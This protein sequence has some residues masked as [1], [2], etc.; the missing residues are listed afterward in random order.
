MHPLGQHQSRGRDRIL[1]L[2]A[3]GAV[4]LGDAFRSAA[5]QFGWP[6]MQ[7]AAAGQA[8]RQIA[9]TRPQGVI[10]LVGTKKSL[11]T[12]ASLISDLRRYQPQLPL[13]AVAEL[14]DEEAERRLRTAGATGYLAG[15]ATCAEEAAD[16]IAAA[17][18]QREP[19]ELV[20]R[21]RAARSPPG[22]RRHR[23]PPRIRGQP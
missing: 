8:L 1:V 22:L 7:N 15:S 6:L 23:A 3:N 2:S 14:H 21:V 4:A 5:E 20:P 13:V 18:P 10:V 17:R 11:Q 9:L 16:L 19:P 12:C